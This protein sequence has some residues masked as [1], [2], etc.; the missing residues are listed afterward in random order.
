V[1]KI[2]VVDDEPYNRLLL[3]TIL[4]HDG[5]ELSEAKNGADGLAMAKVQRPDL[6]IMDLHMPTMSGTDFVKALRADASL[7]NI[8]VALYTATMTDP[9]LLQF[10]EATGIER[11]I[12]KPSE[13]R[14]VLNLVHE[15]LR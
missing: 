4:E 15:M 5:H 6:I 2:L 11:V 3:A 12:P 13:P 14:E 1:A 10:M 8:K 9:D 7:A